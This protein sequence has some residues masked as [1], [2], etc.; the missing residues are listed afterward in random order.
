MTLASYDI[1][2]SVEAKV[3]NEGKFEFT[4]IPSEVVTL[5]PQVNGYHPSS[6]NQSYEQMNAQFLLGT[7]D[8]DITDLTVKLEP[9]PTESTART[10]RIT[11]CSSGP[12]D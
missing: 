1:G 3:D 5:T 8:G 4:C 11:G 2:D 10:F 12:E 7:V 9:G 6:E